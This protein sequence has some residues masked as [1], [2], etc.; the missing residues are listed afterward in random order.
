M[1]WFCSTSLFLNPFPLPLLRGSRAQRRGR[2][3]RLGCGRE[4][5]GSFRFRLAAKKSIS[6]PQQR[7]GGGDVDP[8]LFLGAVLPNGTARGA[9][10]G[11]RRVESAKGG[12]HLVEE[13]RSG[14]RKR[15]GR[16]GTRA[17]NRERVS[18]TGS[19]TIGPQGF[20]V[21][22]TIS[23]RRRPSLLCSFYGLYPIFDT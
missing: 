14:A 21:W 3:G 1:L 12:F 5:A 17:P 9:G 20:Q 8:R 10:A 23:R 2:C 11:P 15:S 7:V 18:L 6:E 22:V 16:R 19:K 13:R 4:P